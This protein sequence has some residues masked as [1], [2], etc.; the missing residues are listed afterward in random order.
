MTNARLVVALA[1][2]MLDAQA[3]AF[4]CRDAAREREQPGFAGCRTSFRSCV[5]GCSPPQ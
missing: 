2:A 3:D 1:S 5:R 4:E